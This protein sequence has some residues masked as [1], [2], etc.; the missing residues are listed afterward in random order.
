MRLDEP[1]P[2]LR[3]QPFG[4][5]LRHR[6]GWWAW[7]HTKAIQSGVKPP[8]AKKSQSRIIFAIEK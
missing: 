2:G 7:P 4:V 3:H 5:R 8:H 1:G 6:F